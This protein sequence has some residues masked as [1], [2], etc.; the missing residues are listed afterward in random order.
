VRGRRWVR[1]LLAGLIALLLLLL[2]LY[3]LDRA[4]GRASASD[5]YAAV[6]VAALVGAVAW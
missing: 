3:A 6:A 5:V 2:A 4:D 1:A